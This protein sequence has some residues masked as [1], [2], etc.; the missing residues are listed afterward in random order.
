MK[1]TTWCPMCDAK[2]EYD[3]PKDL[4][5]MAMK[6]GRNVYYIVCPTCKKEILLWT[7]KNQMV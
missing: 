6:D 7:V 2:I 4:K 5:I 1:V 3:D